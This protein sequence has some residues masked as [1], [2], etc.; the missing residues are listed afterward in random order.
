MLD[1]V[2][3][4]FRLVVALGEQS[5]VDRRVC[6]GIPVADAG[7]ARRGNARIPRRHKALRGA[8]GP[9][10]G[11]GGSRQV[12]QRAGEFLAGGILRRRPRGRGRRDERRLHRDPRLPD[13]GPAI[14]LAP[15]RGWS[16]RGRR[17]NSKPGSRS[18]GS[19]EYETPIRHRDGHLVWVA[20]SINLVRGT[21]TDRDVHVGTVR[22]ITAERA[23]AARES[24]VLA[25]GHGR[26]GGQK[27]GGGSGDHPGRV[28]HDGRRATRCRGYLAYRPLP[29][30]NRP[31]RWRASP[32]NRRGASSIRGCAQTFQ[33]ARHQLPLTARPVERPDAPGK[34]QGLVAALFGC[35]ERHVVAGASRAPLGQ[36]RG[37]AAGHG[38]RRPP[39]PGHPACPPIRERAR[40]VADPAARDVAAGRAAGGFRGSLRT[41]RPAAG[42]R[43]RLV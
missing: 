1:I 39:Q 22:D 37:P 3:H 21:G 17:P 19:A 14:P 4:H 26:R 5:E 20:V 18:N 24:A 29:T 27:R 38:A 23:F 12:P 7:P 28:P 42:N 9:R 30:A 11:S 16:T 35:G 13:G 15:S 41:R 34:S 33:D 8:T 32:S 31:S 43:G 10:R 6:P 2:E 36:R 40:N 25:P